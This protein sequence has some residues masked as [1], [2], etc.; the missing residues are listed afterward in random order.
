M[1]PPSRRKL[2]RSI[3]PAVDAALANDAILRQNEE[4]TRARVDALEAWAAMFSAMPWR[5]R[6]R[7]ML[8]GA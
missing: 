1:P 3:A 7:W 8:F 6:W 4:T 5:R 2:A